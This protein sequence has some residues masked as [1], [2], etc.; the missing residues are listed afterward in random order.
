MVWIAALTVKPYS[1]GVTHILSA[2]PTDKRKLNQNIK[3]FTAWATILKL[4]PSLKIMSVASVRLLMP[5][6][7][8]CFRSSV[9]NEFYIKVSLSI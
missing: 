1:Y 8:L 7:L 3:I 5:L 4:I 6:A 9:Y 2:Q